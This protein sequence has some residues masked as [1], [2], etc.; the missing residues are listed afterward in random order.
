MS[1]GAG[2]SARV[3]ANDSARGPMVGFALLGLVVGAWLGEDGWSAFSGAALGVIYAA[4]R[5]AGRRA[6]QL[7]DALARIELRLGALER[8]GAPVA[9][10]AAAPTPA[11]AAAP[12]SAVF[13]PPSAAE[14]VRVEIVPSADRAPAPP[15]AP[16]SFDRALAAARDFLFG[17]NTVVR[18]GVLVTLFGVA[19]LAKW[20]VDRDLFPIEARLALAAAIGLAL[21]AVGYRLRDARPGFATTLQGGGIAALYLV[22][23]FAYRAYALVPAPLAFALFVAIA[24]ACGVLALVQ[25]SQPLIFIGSVGGFLAPILASTGQDRHLILFS[26]YLLLDLGVAAVAWR[27]AWRALNLL[28]FFSTYAVATAWGVLSYRPEHFATTEPFVIAYLVLFT[29]VAL[30]NAWRTSP[31]LAG[32]VDGTLVFGTPLV[33]LL[34]QGRLVEGRQL[35]MALSTA[36][37]ALFYA[38]LATWVWRRGPET[39]RRIGEAFLALGVAFGTIAIPLAIDDALTTTLVWALEGAGIYWVGTRQR[40]WLARAS[41]VALQGIAAAAFCFAWTFSSFSGREAHYIALANLRFLSGV[42]IAIAGLFIAREAYALRNRLAGWEW[43]AAQLLAGWGLLWWAGVWSAEIDQF[44]P[45]SREA[46]ASL[47]LTS[48]T[49]VALERAAAALGWLPGRLISL[50]VIPVAFLALPL[51]L[52]HEAHLFAG[53]SALAWPLLVACVYELL[54]RLEDCG[55]AWTRSGYA[56]ALW[57]AALVLGFGV[58]GVVDVPLDLHGDWPAAAFA[59]GPVVALLGAL[60][61]AARG[62]GAFGRFASLHLGAGATP[63][64]GLAAFWFLALNVHARGDSAPLPYLPL[65]GPTDLALALLGIALA[66]WWSRVRAQSVVLPG[67][68]RAAVA[69][70]FAALAFAWLNGVLARSV[71][72]WAGVPHRFEALWDATPFQSAVSISWTLVALGAMVWSTQ[73]GR[74]APWI[75]A[76][77][78]LGLTVLKLFLIDLSKLSTGTKIATFLV[79]GALLLVVGYLSPVPPARAEGAQTGGA[80]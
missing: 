27:K 22:V 19:L 37:F 72:Q 74:R 8:D 45:A 53:L 38:L 77:T 65:L 25:D 54:R 23:F 9:A 17:G 75:A 10:P 40:R 55:A 26:Y 5:A 21:T 2:I 73:R 50:A 68:W 39:L 78:L 3:R 51:A 16:S 42:A 1:S 29:G 24:V 79:V 35:G 20:A 60:H 33:S 70:G 15:R 12:A 80:R 11:P 71:V 64:A 14:P 48:A 7:G 66:D 31:R 69:P 62:V 32:I 47:F 52:A 36:G 59:L 28:A 61:L 34:A 6:A 67:E 46:A 76:A 49:F 13:A 63:V 41:G 43:P 30:V 57:L 44:L 4:L 56:P 58:A 18:V